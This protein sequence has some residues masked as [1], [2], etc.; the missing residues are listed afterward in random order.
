MTR[1][2]LCIS[3]AWLAFCAQGCARERATEPQCHAIFDRIVQIE[4]EEMGFR[5]AA[6]AARRTAELRARY[7]SAIRGCV[8]HD[9]SANALTCVATAKT[10]EELSHK[11]LR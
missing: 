5:D 10:T 4:L 11:C 7:E 6:L 8:G 2:C 9:I 3:A 1:A